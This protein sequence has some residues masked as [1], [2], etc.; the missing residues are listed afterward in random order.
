MATDATTDTSDSRTDTGMDVLVLATGLVKAD[1][2]VKSY[3]PI[4]ERVEDALAG[5]ETMLDEPVET[6][7]TRGSPE[8]QDE[9]EKQLTVDVESAFFNWVN[10]LNDTAEVDDFG[11]VVV[12]AVKKPNQPVIDI[13][14]DDYSNDI[15]W[16]EI[17]DGRISRARAKANAK[18][19]HY[20]F[21]DFYEK[22]PNVEA[23]IT[24][25]CGSHRGINEIRDAR[26]NNDWVEG[27]AG[28][29][30]QVIDL[31]CQDHILYSRHL[32]DQ[33]DGIS[34]EDLHETQIEEL[35]KHLSE[36]EL[37]EYGI[38]VSGKSDVKTAP[39]ASA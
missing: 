19:N 9:L 18:M 16:Q 34:V 32:V 24:L 21:D 35:R 26:G 27:T 36:E 5:L 10:F 37:D 29:V 13:D 7:H 25:N 6:V 33:A 22:F 2:Y 12:P 30:D 4:V 39:Q 3:E 38:T 15:P 1:K 17:D 23:V 20:L 28:H 8:L 31:N 14:V 11:E